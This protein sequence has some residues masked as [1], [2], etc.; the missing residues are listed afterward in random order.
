M[1]ESIRYV[2]NIWLKLFFVF[3]P[4]LVTSIFLGLTRELGES[5]RRRAALHATSAVAVICYVVF[6]FGSM[7]FSLFGITLDAFRV[8][9]GALLFLSSINLVNGSTP[10][11]QHDGDDFVV[12]PFAMP[13]VVGPAVMGILFVLGADAHDM[14]QRLLGAL[15]VG[16]AMIGRD[17]LVILSKITGLILAALAAQMIF[18]GI[19]N[20]LGLPN[21]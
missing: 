3:T 8:G 12:V 11:P 17:K 20:F 9:A 15:A 1:D 19:K 4:F 18:T 13:M 6:F 7:I 2:V 10:P 5:G 14:T 16:L 21:A